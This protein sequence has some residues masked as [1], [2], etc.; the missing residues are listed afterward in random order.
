MKKNRGEHLRSSE[1]HSE[2]LYS[3]CKAAFGLAVPCCTVLES[4]SDGV[5]TVDFEK[6][7]TF[8][9]RAAETITGFKA[10]EA[11]GQYCF[12]I[13]R[14]DICQAKCPIDAAIG[15]HP[16][17]SVHARIIDKSGEQ[18][19]V[20]INSALLKDPHGEILGGVETFRDLSELERLRRELSRNFTTEDI[21]GNHPKMRKILSLL[22]DI[23]E[24]DSPVLIE[25]PT[26]SGKELFARAIHNLSS[27]KD[28]P[29]IAINCAALPETLLESEL[30]GY[31]RGAFT[32]ALK[33]KPGRFLLANKGTLFLDEIGTTLPTFQADLLRVLEDGEFTPLGE[34]KALKVDVRVVA[35]TN[36]DLKKLVLQGR[37]RE[38]LY[39]RLN[40]VK[41]SVPPLRE[42][43]E[44]IPLLIDH[45]IQKFNFLKGRAIRGVAPDALSFLMD[46]SFPGNIRE[47]EN[48]IQYAF[49]RCKS[50][51]IAMEHLPSELFDKA[52]NEKES[53]SDLGPLPH[54]KEA[55]QIRSLLNQYGGNRIETAKA[56]GI[57]RS[58]LWR[59]IKKY[60]LVA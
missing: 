28:H 27:R 24:S 55:E 33:N 3:S 48:V 56:L 16:Q 44:D 4:I 12:D 18:R 23:A 20:C 57:S 32:G 39:Y 40:V 19:P 34:T 38:D 8:F 45:F 47:L 2:G 43:K 46:Y 26:G 41:I 31:S 22:P 35:A 13:F 7:I 59:K 10:E 37:F 50:D 11:I 1:I 29:F 53:L 58:T 5:F 49:I 51:L 25:G 6:K 36:V 21:V 14:T 60:G 17:I 52:A 15:G 54:P 30:F 9:N 42:R